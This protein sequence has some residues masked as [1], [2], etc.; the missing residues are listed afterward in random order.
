MNAPL[1]TTSRQPLDAQALDQLFL[2]ARTF[3]A[4]LDKP[5]SDALLARAV[6]LAKMAPTSVNCSPLRLVFVRS[7]EAKAKL[8]PALAEGNV[9]K[10]MAAP[11]TAIIGHDLEFYEALPRLFPHMDAKPWFSGNAEFAATTAFRNGTLQGA[12]LILALRAVGLDTGPMSGFNN[13]VVD[14]TFFAGTNVKSNFLLNIGYGSQEKL[15]ARSPRF[16]FKEIAKIV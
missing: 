7:A 6:D 11:V 1:K 2:E 12:Y 13:A 9:E 4:W 16:D 3:N 15:F 14:E 10:T 5:V 8:K